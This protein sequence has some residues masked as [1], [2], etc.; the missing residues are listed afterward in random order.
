MKSDALISG[1]VK[2]ENALSVGLTSHPKHV[3][4]QFARTVRGRTNVKLYIRTP[5]GDRYHVHENG[6]IQRLDQHPEGKPFEASGQWKMR[7]LQH[8]QKSIFIPLANLFKGQIPDDTTYKNGN[9]Q[10]TV[11][12]FDHGTIR[13]WGN[14]KYHGVAY[15]ELIK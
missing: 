1:R 15:I 4:N 8:V 7:G 3:G 12:D 14:T 13:E 9:P 11:R 5:Y 10:W 6:D 2:R